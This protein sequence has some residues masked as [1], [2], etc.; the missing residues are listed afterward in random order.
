MYVVKR[1]KLHCVPEAVSLAGLAAMCQQSM[2]SC[3]L[4]IFSET[5]GRKE[6]VMFDKITSRISKLC[7]GLNPDFVDPVRCFVCL[8]VSGQTVLEPNYF[9]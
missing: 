5:D 6:T 8:F 4:C 7:Y 2:F 9:F 3:Y 1:G